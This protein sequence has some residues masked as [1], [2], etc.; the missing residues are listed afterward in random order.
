QSL[1]TDA[2]PITRWP[3]QDDAFY[4]VAEGIRKV[5]EQLKEFTL[6][7]T[8]TGYTWSVNSIVIS[9]DGLILVSGSLDNTIKVWNLHT[10]K[11]LYTLT[12]HTSSIY[13]VAISPDGHT[14]VSGS[15]D[16]TIKVW[17]LQ[18]GKELYTLT[19]HTDAV[20]SVAISPDGQTLVSASRDMT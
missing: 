2:L 3:D 6:H 5:A 16:S 20:M 14:L 15:S 9:P 8:L 10:G 7:D 4:D 1:P 13:S 18:T 17:N 19:G 11:E 12:G